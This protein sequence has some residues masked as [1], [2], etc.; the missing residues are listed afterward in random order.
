[1]TPNVFIV[2]RRR[3]EIVETREAHN[4]WSNHGRLYLRDRVAYYP[5]NPEPRRVKYMSLGLGSQ[6]RD[7]FTT[8]P[9]ISLTHS[10]GYDPRGTVGNTYI[11]ADL[12]ASGNG[13]TPAI[14]T[15]EL[16][17]RVTGVAE[18]YPVA[19]SSASSV[20]Y[21]QHPELSHHQLTNRRGLVV[22]G[23]VNCSVGQYIFTPYTMMPIT[24][25]GLHLDDIDINQP[26]EPL[27]AYVS[28]ATLMLDAESSVELIWQVKVAP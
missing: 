5:V 10:P 4:S 28:F 8:I 1:M 27:V 3:G 23:V 6:Y 16:P 9:P 25:A 2:H 13:S 14:S 17:A 15:L 24:E 12:E 18:D 22:H 20:W 26:Y 19:E 7:Y 21:I 11:H